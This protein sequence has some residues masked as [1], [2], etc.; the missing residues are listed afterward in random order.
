MRENN[1]RM[2]RSRVL[3]KL[4]QGN[5]ATCMK[6]NLAD[7]RVIEIAAIAGFD[8]LWTDMEH[9][10]NDL[11]AIEKQVLAGKAYDVDVVVRVPRGSYS[12][13]IKPLEMD[14]TGIMVPH[15]MSLADA[16]Q[17]I[18]QTKFHPIGLRPLDSGNAD[19]AFCNIELTE[20][21]KQ[22]NE[23][24]F[25]ILQ[26]EDPEPL[27]ELEEIISLPGLDMIFFGPGDFSQA[28]GVPGQMTHHKITETRKRIA[29]LAQ[30]NGKFAGTVGGMGDFDALT[31][32]G[33]QFISVGADVIGLS[34][35]FTNIIDQLSKKPS[36]QTKSIYDGQ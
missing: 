17:I 5:V 12:D 21:M 24:R 13:L 6:V 11:S 26:I 32:M 4:R 35:Y 18:K 22:A 15:V 16:Q 23:E 14:A 33:Y 8:C 19:G 30:K 34:Q 2:R 20:Y 3:D 1:I 27:P 36:V 28:I 25:N 7:A 29:E 31:G 10:P 9:V